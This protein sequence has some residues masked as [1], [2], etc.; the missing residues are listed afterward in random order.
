[1]Q[2]LTEMLDQIL[3]ENGKVVR[4]RKLE[5]ILSSQGTIAIIDCESEIPLILAVQLQ[6]IIQSLLNR[7][8]DSNFLT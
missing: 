1:V 4:D 2:I 5:Y 3:K 8:A 6:D 7:T